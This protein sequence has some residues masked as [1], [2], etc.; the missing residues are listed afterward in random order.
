[1]NVR[2]LETLVFVVLLGLAAPAV[3]DG[4]EE[5]DPLNTPDGAV[6]L[7][8]G[9]ESA[10]WFD[11]QRSGVAASAHRQSLPGDA[12]E[13]IYKRYID[14]FSAPI[15]VRFPKETTTAGGGGQ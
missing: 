15:P 14:S 2:N 11:L 8:D 7:I 5:G 3:A 4:H 13:K 6:T 10:A 9:S 1:M 12:M